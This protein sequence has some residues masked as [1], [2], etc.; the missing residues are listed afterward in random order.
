M[1]LFKALFKSSE[2]KKTDRLIKKARG[3]LIV[4]AAYSRVGGCISSGRPGVVKFYKNLVVFGD[5]MIPAYKILRINVISISVH[6]EPQINI[7]ITL[8]NHREFF[9]IVPYDKPDEWTKELNW[10]LALVRVIPILEQELKH[11]TKVGG[12]DDVDFSN[13]TLNNDVGVLL[14]IFGQEL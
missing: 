10:Q 7:W 13:S 2:Q 6:E 1:N 3:N 5:D 11:T 8:A 14:Q 4:R 9:F 12:S